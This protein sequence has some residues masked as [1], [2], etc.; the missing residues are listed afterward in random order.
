M[1][2]ELFQ[3]KQN[4]KELGRNWLEK[5]LSRHFILQSK[6]NHILDQKQLPA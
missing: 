6:Y 1:A 3:V 4:F 5:F 2:K